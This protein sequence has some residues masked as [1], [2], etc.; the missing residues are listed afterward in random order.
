MPETYAE[1]SLSIWKD[2]IERAKKDRKNYFEERKINVKTL[3][4]F[5][6]GN[7]WTDLNVSLP[8]RPTIN[9]IFQHVKS[10]LPYLYFQN[11]RW[12]V[13][14][15]GRFKE[16]YEPIAV[17]A[18]ELLNY[19]VDENLKIS[20]KRQMRLAILDAFFSYGCIK[21]GYIGAFEP[22]PN[23]GQYKILGEKDGQPVYSKDDNG[24][25]ITDDDKEIVTN[26][27]FLA[28]R[29]SP[30]HM[31][32]DTECENYFES[33]RWIAQ[34]IIKSTEDVINSRLYDKKNTNGLK[35]NYSIAT[36]YDLDTK[37][38][39]DFWYDDAEAIKED[40]KRVRLYEIYDMEHD[41]LIVIADG[42]DKILRNE[43]MPD[44]I[45]GCPFC[46]LRF[47]EVPDEKYPLSDIE[48]LKPIQEEYNLGRGMVLTHAKRYG[49]KY[50][51]IAGKF[52]GEDPAKEIEKMKDPEDG[53]MFEV[54]EL[55]LSG[56]IEPL[57]DAP[58]DAAVYSSF[59]QSKQDFREVGG[60]TEWD[61]GVVERRK[62]AYE[63]SKLSG[64]TNVRKDD[65]ITLVEDFS[66]EIGTKMLQSMQA[67]LSTEEAIKIIGSAGEE[68]KIISKEDIVGEFNVDVQIGTAQPRNPDTEKGE[69]MELLST[70]TKLPPQI[71]LPELNVRGTLEEI[72]KL[73]PH[74]KR[75]N[76]FNTP[77]Q[78]QMIEQKMIQ[79]EQ[80]QQGSQGGGEQ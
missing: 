9:L 53:M 25:L 56:V 55:P 54:N 24:Q 37:G 41:K 75:E 26:E 70:L 58:L 66:S 35:E 14:A 3:I 12:Y 4:N 1:K 64:A 18:E 60:A 10:Q 47:N 17:I 77:E 71:I 31:L 8:E 50:G 15:K 46:F 68:W 32:F 44:G 73:Y 29:I 30:K 51:F 79:Q 36:G 20:L 23:Y 57:A 16:S 22:N 45:E 34:E 42:H 80:L 40:V 69:L 62:T 67:N 7:Q 39:L 21:I 5:Y 52:G 28:T 63:A 43:P 48:S 72:I 49:R 19:Y 38:S 74:I 76:I 61:R 78:K 13:R 65:R 59:E 2:R 11:P 6:R 33:G 27:A